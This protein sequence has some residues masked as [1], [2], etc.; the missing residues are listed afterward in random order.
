MYDDTGIYV[1]AMLYD[2]ERL[3]YQ[4]GLPKEMA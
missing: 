1:G 4:K 2:K 3:K